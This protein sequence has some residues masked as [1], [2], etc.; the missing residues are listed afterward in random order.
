[1]KNDIEPST[2]DALRE[3]VVKLM[4]EIKGTRKE[5]KKYGA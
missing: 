1:M 3:D 2:I 4:K 5:I